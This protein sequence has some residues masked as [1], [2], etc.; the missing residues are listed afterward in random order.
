MQTA[1]PKPTAAISETASYNLPSTVISLSTVRNRLKVI[2]QINPNGLFSIA[3]LML[4]YNN[5]RIKLQDA[6]AVDRN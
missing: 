1:V 4:D 5:I 3:A 2:I 6:T